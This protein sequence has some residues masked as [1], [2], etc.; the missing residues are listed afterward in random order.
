MY[1]KTLKPETDDVKAAEEKCAD[2][3]PEGVPFTE[4]DQR[5]GDPAPSRCYV[6]LPCGH[7]DQ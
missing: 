7:I 6:F 4:D 1:V 2:K 3:Y 5:H